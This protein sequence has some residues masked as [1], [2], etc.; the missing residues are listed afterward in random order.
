VSDDDHRWLDEPRNVTHIVRGL[1]VLC[2]LAL[3]AD[4]FYTKHPHFAVEAL[5]GF[6]AVYGFTVSMGLVLSAKWLRR[7]VRRDEDY[8]E[9][10]NAERDHDERPERDRDAD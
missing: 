3:V 5:P 7:L 2:G 4:F 9:R 6:Y 10:G 1:G 8:Y